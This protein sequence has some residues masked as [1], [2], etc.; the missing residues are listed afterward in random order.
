MSFAGNLHK[1]DVVKLGFGNVELIMSNPL[2]SLFSKCCIKDTETF[3]IY[4]CMARRRYMPDLINVEI[5][6]FSKIAPTAGFFTY[7][8]F[9]HNCGTNELLNQTLTIL[10]L[11]EKEDV[12]YAP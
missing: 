5:K 4:A 12:D 6:P 10:A 9:Y 11:S 2:K 7:G 3:F 1:G 8:E